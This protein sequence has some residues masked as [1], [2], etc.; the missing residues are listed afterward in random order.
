MRNK[1]AVSGIGTLIIFIALI[2]IAA[3]AATVLLQTAS[4]LQ[5][6]ALQTGRESEA[7][8]SSQL[9]V[10]AVTGHTIDYNRIDYLRM[11]VSL[12]PGSDNVDLTTTTMTLQTSTSYTTGIGY[13]TTADNNNTDGNALDITRTLSGNSFSVYYLGQPSTF[14]QS[15][16]SG[17]QPG[18]QVEIFLWTGSLLRNAKTEV[19]II[20]SI[21]SQ[22]FVR[23]RTPV[24][25]D[26][27]FVKLFP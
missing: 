15:A 16:K 11:V 27:N 25:F 23:F 21:G 2:L 18:Q 12:A 8:A 13:V 4:A 3:I 1:K 20:P 5:S 17:V 6:R 24:L 9:Q 19:N 26:G 14:Q 10:E 7:Q 22:T